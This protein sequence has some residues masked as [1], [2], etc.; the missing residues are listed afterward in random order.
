MEVNSPI[1]HGKPEEEL[2]ESNGD[3]LYD[4]LELSDL[5]VLSVAALVSLVRL[6]SSRRY[7]ALLFLLQEA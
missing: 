2:V 1:N 7:P 6:G 4:I 3:T 5:E